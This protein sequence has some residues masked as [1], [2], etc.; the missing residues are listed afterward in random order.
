MVKGPDEPYE[1]HANDKEEEPKTDLSTDELLKLI[2]NKRRRYTIEIIYQL[3]EDEFIPVRNLAKKLTARE[4]DMEVDRVTTKD[5]R[6]QYITL[7]QG[8]LEKLEDA[9]IIQY[10]SDSKLVAKAEF[11]DYAMEVIQRV[12][13]ISC[14]DS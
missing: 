14:D 2:G 4:N 3:N 6:S 11:C 10:S 12:D 13:E 9:N 7:I 1:P 5:S 8:H